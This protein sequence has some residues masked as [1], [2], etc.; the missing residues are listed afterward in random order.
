MLRVSMLFTFLRSAISSRHQTL[1]PK[2]K[3]DIGC[4]N[5]LK[6]SNLTENFSDL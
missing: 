2:T 5:S 1:G 6:N 3:K 4:H